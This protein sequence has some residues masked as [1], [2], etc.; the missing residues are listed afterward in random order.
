MD[1][2]AKGHL[3]SPEDSPKLSTASRWPPMNGSSVWRAV[4]E[5]AHLLSVLL[6][7]LFP[8]IL[9]A[10]FLTGSGYL[11]ELSRAYCAHFER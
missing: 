5:L 1:K 4:R 10:R 11:R 3:P 9:A 8:N 7:A 6:H 2:K